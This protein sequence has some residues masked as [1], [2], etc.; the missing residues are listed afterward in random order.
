MARLARTLARF[1][2]SAERSDLPAARYVERF[3]RLQVENRRVLQMPA[4]GLAPSR[5]AAVL[6]RIDAALAHA[7]RL[8]QHRVAERRIVEGHGDL[9]P[10]HVCM[11][12]PV[13]VFDCLEFDRE[14][15]LVDPYDEIGFLGMECAILGRPELG[16][17]LRQDLTDRLGDPPPPKLTRFYAAARALLRARLSLAHLLD[18]SPRDAE[19]WRPL[20]EAYLAFAESALA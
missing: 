20:A 9:R 1:Y 6:D 16:P 3:V 19:R 14:L 10:E 7:A 18:P 17:Q 15:R 11:S 5:V 4:L 13:V 8:L 12:D 2:R